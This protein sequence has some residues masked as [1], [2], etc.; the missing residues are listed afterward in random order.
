MLH[1]IK[2]DLNGDFAHFYEAEKELH[3][4]C[5]H[6]ATHSGYYLIQTWVVAGKRIKNLRLFFLICPN[7][8]V[9]MSI[10]DPNS[11]L[12]SALLSMK[13]EGL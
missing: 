3:F 8:I 13:W 2:S 1:F 11:F 10:Y 7:E 5:T 9:E 6:C 4:Y 12:T